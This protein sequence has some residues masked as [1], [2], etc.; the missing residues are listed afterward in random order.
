[1]VYYGLLYKVKG[2][3]GNSNMFEIP[4]FLGDDEYLQNPMMRRFLKDRG[5]ELVE[6]KADYIKA[7]EEYANRN[8]ANG[9][10]VKQ[11]LTKTIKEGSKDFCYRKL[12][13]G[14][15]IY[16]NLATISGKLNVDFPDCP[17]VE[18][19]DYRHTSGKTLINYDII[20]N[21]NDEVVR[22]DFIYSRSFLC[23]EIGKEGKQVIFPLFIEIYL[24][25]GF[26]VSRGKAKST[27][28][29]YNEDATD[30]ILRTETKV[31]AM[32]YAI[33]T[34][35]NL[36]HLLEIEVETDTK[37]VKSENS[38]VL[39]KIYNRYSFT[40]EDVV[41]KVNREDK[42]TNQF[43][44]TLFTNLVL[45]IKNKPM[46]IMDARILIEKFIS[47]NGN[48]EDVFKEDRVA[49]LIKVSADNDIELTK[50]D[51]MSDKNVPLQ[52]TEA[53]FDSKKTVIKSKSC[54][55][56]HLIFKRENAKYF[57]KKN[58]LVVQ[59]GTHKNC[60]YIKTMQY[61]EEADIQNVL[62]AIFESY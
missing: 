48:N 36:L 62:Q 9:R 28:F 2:I 51:T 34:I 35:D 32:S 46:A 18:V 42:L 31:D 6:T 38:Q 52:C 29:E 23:G 47:I 15:D 21:E 55:R 16:K 50:S 60:A 33:S 53:F 56:L 40:P 27:L 54:K 11:W 4:K 12:K 14:E 43:I 7:I 10:E 13:S 3:W 37:R 39:Y 25:Q 1:M 17:K 59:L 20:T 44:D 22:V 26:V 57:L 24:E 19:L 30:L 45:D 49:Y 8:V 41:E 58:P 61:A 5:L